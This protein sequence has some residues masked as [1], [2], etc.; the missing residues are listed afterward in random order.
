[1]KIDWKF[2]VV[3]AATLAGVVVPVWLWRADLSSR[4]LHFKKISQTSLQPPDTAKELDLKVS[5][6]GTELA[7]P[8][9]TVFELINDGDKPIPATDY[10]SSIDVGVFN[11]AKIARAMIT[12][13]QPSD[14]APVLTTDANTI[15][16][17]AMLFNPGDRLSLAVLTT[18]EKPEFTSRARIAGVQG[19]PIVD[20]AEI[21]R[22]PGKVVITFFGA[23]V[24][25]VVAGL[26]EDGWP[27]KGKQLRARAAFL[28]YTFAV[29]PGSLLLTLGLE[30]VGIE[31]ILPLAASFLIFMLVGGACASWLNKPPKQKAPEPPSFA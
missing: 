13:K 21:S 12:Q 23:I 15:S 2:W 30:R 5:I 4:S 8:H 7:T 25:F 20:E 9:L 3:L 28:I 22:S 29:L 14:L 26:V 16:L 18:G 24:C 17:K 31:G 1:M 19:V 27:F 10:E 6:A 11:G